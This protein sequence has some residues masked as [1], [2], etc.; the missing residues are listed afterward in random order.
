MQIDQRTRMETV[1]T[2]HSGVVT[3]WEKQHCIKDR[4]SNTEKNKWIMTS[5]HT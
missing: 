1:E 5:H 4:S 3:L 2:A